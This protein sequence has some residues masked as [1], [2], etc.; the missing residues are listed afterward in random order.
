MNKKM[1]LSE[2]LRC[3]LNK[4]ELRYAINQVCRWKSIKNRDEESMFFG[5]C[6]DILLYNHWL[7]EKIVCDSEKVIDKL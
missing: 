5:L 6:I 7:A 2:A 4:R 1:S 3:I